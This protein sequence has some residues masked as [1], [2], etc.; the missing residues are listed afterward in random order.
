MAQADGAY[1]AATG[2]KI[3][4]RKFESGAEVIAAV[5]SGDVPIGNIGSSPLAAAASR[6]LPIQTFW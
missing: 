6:G 1:E 3:N 2:S 4:W 5:A